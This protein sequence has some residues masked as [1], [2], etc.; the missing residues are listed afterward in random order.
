MGHQGAEWIYKEWIGRGQLHKAPLDG[1]NGA[2]DFFRQ[3]TLCRL[4]I[5]INLVN[6]I[7]QKKIDIKK[8]A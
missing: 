7:G 4:L 8:K 6:S 3:P 1:N 5:N 2:N